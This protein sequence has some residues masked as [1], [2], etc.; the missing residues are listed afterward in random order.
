MIYRDGGRLERL[1][2]LNA[3]ISAASL[4]GPFAISGE[5]V[6]YGTAW[7]FSFSVGRL[8]DDGASALALR[9]TLPAS[10]STLQFSG[11]L[12]NHPEGVSLRGSI[13]LEGQDFAALIAELGGRPNNFTPVLSRPFG[14]QAE[15]SADR[16]SLLAEDMSLSL[17]DLTLAGAL[18]A[19]LLKPGKLQIALRATRLDLDSLFSEEGLRRHDAPV[20]FGTADSPTHAPGDGAAEEDEFETAASETRLLAIDPLLLE[21][22]SG[23]LEVGI[24]TLVYR[25]RVVRQLSINARMADGV[26]VLEQARA[27]L[28]GG[29]DIALSGEFS[30]LVQEPRFEGGM[31]AASDNFRGFLTWVGLNVDAIPSNRLRKMNVSTQLSG[32]AK[33]ITAR[34]IDLTVDVSR[35]TG[36]VAVAPRARPGLGIG[37][38]L[39]SINLDAYLPS[40]L[41]R[42][43]TVEGQN[44]D[45]PAIGDSPQGYLAALREF[46][47]S[48]DAN[49][50]LSVG[51]L[52]HR[53]RQARDIEWDATLRQGDLTIRNA[54]FGDIGGATGRY[55]GRLAGLGEETRLDGNLDLT[56]PALDR[57]SRFFG[58]E[59]KDLRKLGAMTFSA[60]VTGGMDVLDIESRLEA[61]GGQFQVAGEAHPALSE[62]D[63]EV[64][65]LHPSLGDLLR[66]TGAEWSLDPD[67]GGIDLVARVAGSPRQLRLGDLRGSLAA[68]DISGNLVLDMTGDRPLLDMDL[69]TAALPLP[70]LLSSGG[71]RAVRRFSSRDQQW[72]PEPLDF[73]ALRGFDAVV[74]LNTQAIMSGAFNLEQARIDAVLDDG[75][76]TVKELAG[77]LYEGAVT[78]SGTLDLRAGV[79]GEIALRATDVNARLLLDEL[80][81]TNRVSG[82]LTLEAQLR[83]RGV[84]EAELVSNLSGDGKIGG[85]LQADPQAGTRLGTALID[86]TGGKVTEIGGL[87]DTTTTLFDAFAGSPASLAG[88]FTLDKGVLRTEDVVMKN[89]EA[90][91]TTQAT[92]DLAAWR[93][94]SRS[95]V[96]RREDQMTPYVTLTL[97][98]P[99]DRPNV[100]LA[101][102][103]FS[104]GEN[105]EPEAVPEGTAP[106][107]DVPPQNLDD[108]LNRALDPDKHLNG[109]PDQD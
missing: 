66:L 109:A 21:E 48:F 42:P 94:E 67:L 41:T 26:V 22:M 51:R 84:S 89:A 33:E 35:L 78:G 104:R 91:A 68:V 105:L 92:L 11:G 18:E 97:D 32:T 17:E 88:S 72:S 86:M 62:W 38:T 44:G 43:S 58:H 14:L 5:A 77:F 63:V 76:V 60:D 93:L 71:A 85:T 15:I 31:E 7:E 90:S 107:E 25:E 50:R 23:S 45:A 98:G 75:V 12:S 6:A 29:S 82:P 19:G 10:Q 52:T 87:T 99:L 80:A 28:P 36:G 83:S 40:S 79:D 49:M 24:D 70:A 103:P 46:L 100:K 53:G 64:T 34:K 16:E 54:S 8:L 2:N 74:R 95:E 4:A 106:G 9:L 57:L 81:D 108:L 37:L 20:D 55:S 96:Y 73:S 39:D 13:V 102:K 3:E 59:S 1:D 69:T 56:V 61:F 47:I 101:G 27:L 65:A 30:D